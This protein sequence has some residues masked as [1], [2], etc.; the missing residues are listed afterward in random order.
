M[1]P[2]AIEEALL[3]PAATLIG[4]ALVPLATARLVRGLARGGAA[5]RTA[6]RTVRGTEVALAGLAGAT[7]LGP[8]L[9]ARAVGWESAAFAIASACVALG[10]GQLA[11]RRRTEGT[12]QGARLGVA[13]GLVIST[14]LAALVLAPWTITAIADAPAASD[15]EARWRLRVDPWDPVA[16]LAAGWSARRRESYPR[17]LAW[18]AE[19]REHG[20]SEPAVLELEAEIFAARGECEQAH[21]RFDQA[22]RARA[23]AAFADPLAAPLELGGYHL[24]PSL[25]TECEAPR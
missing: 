15:P 10:A 20:A 6:D 17:A 5:L 7:A 9:V 22:L 18:A 21:A 11:R 4:S 2:W 19:A 13:I 8:A 3:R 16:M 23:E 14:T 24:P 25:L 12:E 1:E